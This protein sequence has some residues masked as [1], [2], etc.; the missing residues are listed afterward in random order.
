MDTF[1]KLS[2]LILYLAS[3][4]KMKGLPFCR[5]SLSFPLEKTWFLMGMDTDSKHHVVMPRQNYASYFSPYYCFCHVNGFLES[6][7]GSATKEGFWAVV[8]RY[9]YKY[10]EKGLMLHGNIKLMLRTGQNSGTPGSSL[11]GKKPEGLWQIFCL[12]GLPCPRLLSMP[13]PGLL[14]L[15]CFTF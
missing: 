1:S 14:C 11:Q 6:Q 5:A 4:C 3:H 2:F 13:W 8:L 9:L 15:H 7:R 10:E 12:F